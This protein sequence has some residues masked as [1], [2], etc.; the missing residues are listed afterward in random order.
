MYFL[1]FYVFFVLFYVFF[2]ILSIFCVVLCIVCFVSFSVLFVCIRMCSELLPPGG[3]PIAAK[4]ITSYHNIYHTVSYHIMSCHIISN[5][6]K[7]IDVLNAVVAFK[8]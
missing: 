8:G 1:L 7:V 3:Y 2:V 6:I 4:Y 5:H